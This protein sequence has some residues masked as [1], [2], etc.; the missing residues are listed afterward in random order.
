MANISIIINLKTRDSEVNPSGIHSLI[1]EYLGFKLH[2]LMNE[3]LLSIYLPDRQYMLTTSIT[4]VEG[5]SPVE[6]NKFVRF[7]EDDISDFTL[8]VDGS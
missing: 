3:Q 4:G 6:L 1:E 8:M 5:E 2:E 7:E